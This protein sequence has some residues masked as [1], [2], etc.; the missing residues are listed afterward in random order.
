MVRIGCFH[1][2]GPGSFPGVGMTSIVIVIKVE[3]WY[4]QATPKQM[5]ENERKIVYWGV[6][7]YADTTQLK[8]NRIDITIINKTKKNVIVIKMSC[9]WLENREAKDIEKTTKYSQMRLELTHRYPEYKIIQYN[10]ITDLLGGFSRE[11]E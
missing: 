4:S 5:Y 8:A 6:H 7:L 11:M 3:P 9:P 2:C 1:L 10:I